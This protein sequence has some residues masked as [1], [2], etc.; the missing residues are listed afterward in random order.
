MFSSECSQQCPSSDS[1]LLSP[2]APDYSHVFTSTDSDGIRIWMNASFS[3]FIQS[4]L[5]CYSLS[6][7]L[8]T[9]KVV[10]DNLDLFIRP[11]TE[12]SDHYADS[13]H[14]F[15]MYAVRDSVDHSCLYDDLRTTGISSVNVDDVLPKP[16]DS[17]AIKKNLTILVCRIIQR[18]M[19]YFRK[20]VKAKTVPKHIEHKF[21]R[22]MS[23]KSEVVSSL[24]TTRSCNEK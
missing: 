9:F 1:G 5:H 18:H 22:E 12:T 21:L 13:K 3:S 16:S 19:P 24:W 11:R 15:Y 7:K 23:Q 6:F 14:F 17:K 10:D 4:T 20:H 8:P 2:K